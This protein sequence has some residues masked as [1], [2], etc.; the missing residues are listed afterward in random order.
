MQRP[1]LA[2]L[3]RLGQHSRLLALKNHGV[4]RQSRTEPRQIFAGQL[5]PVRL[6]PSILARRLPAES[7]YLPRAEALRPLHSAYLA[8]IRDHY[9]ATEKNIC[10]G[11][12]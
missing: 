11:S 8:L 10:M 12:I 7:Q 1:L 4:S 3:G 9:L 6:V 2:E 5:C